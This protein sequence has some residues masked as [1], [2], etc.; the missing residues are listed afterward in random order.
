MNAANNINNNDN[1]NNNNNN[2]NNNNNNNVNIQ[3]SNNNQNNMN[4]ATAGRNLPLAEILRLQRALARHHQEAEQSAATQTLV[5]VT[6]IDPVTGEARNKTVILPR[7][8]MAERM[9]E[10]RPPQTVV[11]LIKDTMMSYLPDLGSDDK[12]SRRSLYQRGGACRVSPGD[13]GRVM[14]IMAAA[15]D[16]LDLVIILETEDRGPGLGELCPLVTEQEGDEVVRSVRRILLEAAMDMW[17]L[18]EYG[19]MRNKCRNM[20]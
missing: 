15:R 2:D 5:S 16:I 9:E 19:E 20:K 3:N 8:K 17:G 10:R 7:I 14:A 1:N 4:M 11:G 18:P 6:D 13:R 12:R